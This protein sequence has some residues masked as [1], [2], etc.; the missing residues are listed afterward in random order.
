[1]GNQLTIRGPWLKQAQIQA[2]ITSFAAPLIHASRHQDGGA[3]ELTLTGLVGSSKIYFGSFTRDM[4]LA[5]GTQQIT[6]LGFAP[7]YVYFVTTLPQSLIISWGFDNATLRKCIYQSS[8]DISQFLVTNSCLY[9]D[10][11]DSITT[12]AQIDSFDTD[13]FTLSWTKEGNPIGI[14]TINYLAFF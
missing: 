5:A 10:Q 12:Q 1:M 8:W 6:G 14:I 2:L 4:E 3:D 9:V 13:G 11:D 7:K